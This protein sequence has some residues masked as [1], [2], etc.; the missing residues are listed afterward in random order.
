VIVN[1][2]GGRGAGRKVFTTVTEPLLKAAG[3]SYTMR[4]VVLMHC[5]LSEA[6]A[7]QGCISELV[8]SSWKGKGSG[9]FSNRFGK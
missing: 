4:G 8:M 9:M 2:V 7:K 5:R 3:I 6:R 1:P